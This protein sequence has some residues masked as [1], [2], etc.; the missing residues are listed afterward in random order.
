MTISH[1]NLGS[2]VIDHLIHLFW[3]KTS[4]DNH[5]RSL[6]ALAWRSS[7]WQQSWPDCVHDTMDDLSDWLQELNQCWP[8]TSCKLVDNYSTTSIQRVAFQT[9]LVRRSPLVLFIK[10]SQKRIFGGK[11][12]T[13]SRGQMTF[14]SPNHQCQIQSTNPSQRN[15]ALA[16]SCLHPPPDSGPTWIYQ[17]RAI[18]I[19]HNPTI[20]V[21]Y[22]FAL[23][24]ADLES[25][26]H[27][28]ETQA[29]E[30][31]TKILSP[32]SCLHCLLP[33]PR[34]DAILTRL[35]NPH[36]YPVNSRRT[37]KYHSFINSGF[38]NYQ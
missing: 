37:K 8:T 4:V 23:T 10:L 30:L 16:A 20:S 28:S 17:K 38:K 22:I 27:R 21:P 29:W 24:Y 35:W 1:M 25:L 19:I 18:R 5:G 6:Q 33:P 34:D 31:F 7:R 15:H 11:W 36:R 2:R 3:K 32:T 9:Y 12:R 13:Y 26:K 14:H